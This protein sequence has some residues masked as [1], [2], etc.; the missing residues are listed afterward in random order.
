MRNLKLLDNSIDYLELSD[1]IIDKLRIN[2]INKICELWELSRKE[3]KQFGFSDV[4]IN[5]VIIKL[6]LHALD[7]NKKFY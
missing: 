2:N 4:E 7:L 3:L 6:Q 5:Q 1:S